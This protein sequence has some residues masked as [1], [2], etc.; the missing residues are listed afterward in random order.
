MPLV[1]AIGLDALA[2]HAKRK[3]KKVG[4]VGA[5]AQAQVNIEKRKKGY[6]MTTRLP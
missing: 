2:P 4:H 6:S 5:N 3:I 1:I